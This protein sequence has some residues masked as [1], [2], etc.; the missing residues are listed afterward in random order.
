[1]SYKI[2]YLCTKQVNRYNMLYGDTVNSRHSND[3]TLG[4]EFVIPGDARMAGIEDVDEAT[5]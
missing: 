5:L 3:D 2:V 1:M 4:I